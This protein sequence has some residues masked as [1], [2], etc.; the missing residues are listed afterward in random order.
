MGSNIDSKN[1]LT[2]GASLIISKILKHVMSSSAEA[3]TGSVFLRAKETTILRI[4]LEEMGHTQPPTPLQ[5][6]NTTATGYIN[7]TIKQRRTHAMDM[8]FY[9]I[10]YRLKQGQFRVYWDPGYQSLADYFT[11]NHSPTHH[12]RIQEM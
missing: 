3:E 10:K 7:D 11:K 5:T 4:T 2:N 12:K 6:D 9:W 1:K 8:H